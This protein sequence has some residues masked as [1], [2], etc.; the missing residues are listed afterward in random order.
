MLKMCKISLLAV[1]IQIILLKNC[2][3]LFKLTKV[4]CLNENPA[5]VHVNACRLKAI[6]RDV[7]EITFRLQLKQVLEHIYLHIELKRK[8]NTY[9][10][11]FINK[12][13]DVCAFLK[14]RKEAVYL[15]I[16]FKLILPYTNANHTCPYE[17]ELIV[18]HF[19]PLHN[20]LI[21][22]I[23]S[24]DY[25]IQ[26]GFREKTNVTVDLFVWFTFKELEA[27]ERFNK[28]SKKSTSIQ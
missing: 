1:I 12:T 20:N 6:S 11:F 24:G 8:Y 3:A 23:P 22:P 14:Y 21:L 15:D 17:G 26:I 9:Q 4:E 5:F 25:L 2:L 7:S 19:R 28:K 13:I 10:P 16:L 18:D 27:W